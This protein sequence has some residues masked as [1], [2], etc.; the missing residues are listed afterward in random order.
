MSVQVRVPSA[1][2]AIGEGCARWQSIVGNVGLV[3]ESE[4]KFIPG[5]RVVSPWALWFAFRLDRI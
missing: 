2:G 1:N 3:G 5:I 4:V